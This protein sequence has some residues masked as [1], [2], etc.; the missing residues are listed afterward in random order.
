MD[1]N[2]KYIHIMYAHDDKFVGPLIHAFHEAPDKYMLDD[3]LFVGQ[4]QRSGGILHAVDEV[5]VVGGIFV[6]QQDDAQ[7]HIAV[8]SGIGQSGDGGQAQHQRHQQ[9]SKF[10]HEIFPPPDNE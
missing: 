7:L 8:I 4:A 2:Y 5:Q 6:V 1:K 3:N 10:L 9:S